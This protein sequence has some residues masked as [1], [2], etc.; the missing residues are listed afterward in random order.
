MVAI[1][2][3]SDFNFIPISF[4]SIVNQVRYNYTNSLIASSG[5]EK[6]I[7]LWSTF[8]L[9]QGMGSLE[10]KSTYKQSRRVFSHEDYIN[11]VLET[12]QFVTHDYSHQS[13]QEDPRMMA[14]FDSLVQRDIEGWTSDSSD[15]VDGESSFYE[16]CWNR[17][18]NSDESRSS[19]SSAD[20]SDNA[21][22]V[23]D[24]NSHYFRYLDVIS[25][26]IESNESNSKV[27][28]SQP[29]SSNSSGTATALSASEI[30]DRLVKPKSTKTN[31]NTL[32]RISELI[33]EKKREQLRKLIKYAVRTTRKKLKRVERRAQTRV[34]YDL[35]NEETESY[36]HK[37][38][39]LKKKLD[40]LA[41]KVSTETNGA[42]SK[43]DR[44]AFNHRNYRR[45]RFLTNQSDLVFNEVLPIVSSSSS[46]DSDD[47]NLVSGEELYNAIS[48]EMSR[49]RSM[50]TADTDDSD[51]SSAASLLS[52]NTRPLQSNTEPNDKQ[53][54]STE[55][56]VTEQ[57]DQQS[58]SQSKE[59]LKTKS[60]NRVSF[61]SNLVSNQ[62]NSESESD[63]ESEVNQLCDPVIH[64]PYKHDLCHA[65]TASTSAQNNSESKKQIIFKPIDSRKRSYRKR[66]RS[67]SNRDKDNTCADSKDKDSKAIDSNER[68]E[69]NDNNDNNENNKSNE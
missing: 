56:D 62:L 16:L 17:T 44:Q 28:T 40:F 5:V 13:V 33:T 22:A 1:C 65:N 67:G 12:G 31:E 52:L 36:K 10:K 21:D 3:I 6:V 4:R 58:N 47:S 39:E 8:P 69:R 57:N 2:G 7:K 43:A 9:P 64:C 34:K 46:S 14:F 59:D 38:S 35:N 18:T 45:L 37:L 68:V 55:E 51:S 29:E 20:E 27:K 50:I 41:E 26:R 19:N 23:P 32:N 60:A 15:S 49:M 42:D 66:K 61:L 48:N 24:L 63:S 30:R 11:L 54:S 53:S 25:K